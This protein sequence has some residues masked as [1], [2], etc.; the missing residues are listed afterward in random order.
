ML[1]VGLVVLGLTAALAETGQRGS[2]AL[3]AW[4]IAFSPLLTGALVRTHFDLVPTAILLGALV[5]MT[6]GRPVLGLGL[7]GVGAMTKLFPALAAP[8]AIAWLLGRGERRTAALGAV[9]FVAVVAVIS[10]PF[11]GNGYIDA[12]RFH[13][14][15]PVQIESTPASVLFAIGGSHVTGDP[16][17]PDQ[18]K[19]NGLAG[20]SAGAVQAGFVVLELLALAW[21]VVRAAR[22]PDP[23]ELILGVF[24]ALLAFAALGKVLSPQFVIWLVPF[25]AL[26][27]AWGRRVPAALCALAILLTQVEFP[28]RYFDLVDRHAGVIVLVAVRNGLLLAALVALLVPRRGDA[29]TLGGAGVYCVGLGR[30]RVRAWSSSLQTGLAVH[31]RFWV[32]MRPK[33]AN[34]RDFVPRRR[35]RP[36]LPPP[37][38]TQ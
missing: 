9:A 33:G 4:L 27:W 2:G 23:R 18:Y 1:L 36:P 14:D 21:I 11:F 13:I 31:W 38:Q 8:V 29:R 16:V 17:R 5:A 10:L 12:Y 25:A 28:S 26:A 34:E 6:R 37:R 22:R 19:S 15:R 3:A 7:L 32:G 35:P 24:A 20:G 30:G